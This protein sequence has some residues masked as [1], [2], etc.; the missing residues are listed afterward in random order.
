MKFEIYNYLPKTSHRAIGLFDF[1]A[2]TRVILAN[3][4]F[5]TV[6]FLFVF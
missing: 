1:D 4:Q 3:T 6:R 5:A 2:T